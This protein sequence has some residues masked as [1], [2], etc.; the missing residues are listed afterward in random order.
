MGRSRQGAPE[1]KTQKDAVEDAPV[2]NTGNATR[3]VRQN[4]PD[5]SPFKVREF[6]AH[7]SRLPVCT[8]ESTSKPMPSTDKTGQP[9]FPRLPRNRTC[10]GRA[11]IDANDP[12]CVKTTRNDM[13]LL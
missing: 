12:D 1:R 5:G 11:K 13:I 3:L 7:D 6:I 10:Y 8:L 9:A 4:R 2:V